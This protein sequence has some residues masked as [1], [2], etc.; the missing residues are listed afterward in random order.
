FAF[1]GGGEELQHLIIRPHHQH[2]LITAYFFFQA[3]DGIRDGHVTGVQTCALPIFEQGAQPVL[4]RTDCL[5]A[6]ERIAQAATR[7]ARERCLAISTGRSALCTI[8][9]ETLPTSAPATA[10]RPCEP[11]TIRSAPRACASSTIRPAGWPSRISDS[12][13]TPV[14]A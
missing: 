13:S 14:S 5:H 7:R 11:M 1:V 3:E 8:S 4:V 10:P 2:V 12:D 6:G 9:V